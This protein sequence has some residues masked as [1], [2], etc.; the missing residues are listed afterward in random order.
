MMMMGGDFQY[1]NAR[2]NYKNIDKLIKYVNA[3]AVGWVS[4][5][6]HHAPVST[7]FGSKYCTLNFCNNFV[8]PRFILKIFG[9]LIPIY[10]CNKVAT[11]LSTLSCEMQIT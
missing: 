10:I 1:Q 7:V 9:M 11:E 5:R 2:I 8:K 6:H 3:A 4:I